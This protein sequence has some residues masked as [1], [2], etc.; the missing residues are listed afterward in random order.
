MGR[1]DIQEGLSKIK[2][3][4]MSREFSL[5]LLIFIGRSSHRVSI[6]CDRLQVAKYI[7]ALEVIGRLTKRNFIN[8]LNTIRI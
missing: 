8:E 6:L 4:T 3:K 1:D 7:R 2:N 5:V